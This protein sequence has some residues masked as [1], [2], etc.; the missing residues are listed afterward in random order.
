MDKLT[1]EIA[2][3]IVGKPIYW[4]A[5]TS[6]RGEFA[7]GK[8]IITEVLPL[9]K[10]LQYPL[11]TIHLEGDE[12]VFMFSVEQHCKCCENISFNNIEY[13]I[14]ELTPDN[15]RKILDFFYKKNEDKYREL[16]NT[17]LMYF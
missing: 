4:R 17:I 5:E 15:K 3:G 7:T 8:A 11:K 13:T 1:M 2:K 16:F 10:G 12:L 6:W 9:H 14:A